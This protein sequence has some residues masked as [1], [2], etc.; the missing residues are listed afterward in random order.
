MKIH[1][2]FAKHLNQT[3]VLALILVL[4]TTNASLAASQP[5]LSDSSKQTSIKNQDASPQK[6]KAAAAMNS[7][8]FTPTVTQTSTPSPTMT[9][10]PL[11][12]LTSTGTPT[13]PTTPTS[14]PTISVP[15]PL[16]TPS[17]VLTAPFTPTTPPSPVTLVRE[18][19]NY[20]NP[21]VAGRES[22]VITYTLNQDAEVRAEIYS[23]TGNLLRAMHFNPG[24]EGG[25]GTAEGYVNRIT[26]DGHN[27][28][29]K[30]LGAGGYIFQLVIKPVDGSA[31]QTVKRKIGIANPK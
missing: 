19:S 29:G 9:D 3:W 26:W 21:F 15:T 5:I 31:S 7:P 20:P 30:S 27:S 2:A 17:V 16:A 6:I 4:F 25:R 23:Y 8:T 18:V 13:I 22:A 12:T 14:T 10:T 28:S 24:E 1:P 11:P